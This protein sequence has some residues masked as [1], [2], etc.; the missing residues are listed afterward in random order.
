MKNSRVDCRPAAG[1]DLLRSISLIAALVVVVLAGSCSESPHPSLE[2][3]V[4]VFLTNDLDTAGSMLARV[5]EHDPGN[6]DARA[7]YAEC[8]RRRQLFDEAHREG[9]AALAIE[10]G[11]SLAHT[12]LGDLF[13]P[14]L[15]S[16]ARTDFDSA[17]A[18]LMAAVESD[19]AEAQAW[20]SVWI[21]SMRR[22]DADMERRAAGAMIESGFLTPAL[23]AYNKWQLEHLPPNAILLT[24]GDMDTYPSV[25]LQQKEGF[26]Q[27]V[28]VINL[29]LLNLPWYARS[30]SK[31]YDIELP[32]TDDELDNL[33]AQ[34]NSDGEIVTSAMQ[35]VAGW[36]D[37]QRRGRL[38]RP[39][40][41]A[42]TVGKL[43]LIEGASDR[44]VLCGAYY[45]LSPSKPAKDFDLER[46][47]KSI[48]TVP[49]AELYG[50]FASEL[51]RSPVRRSGSDEIARNVTAV[52][53][54][55]VPLLV[56]EGRLDDA[57]QALD[58]AEQFDSKIK[59]GG[60]YEDA[61]TSLRRTIDAGT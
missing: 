28:A 18:H 3:S 13:S 39:L 21:H 26:R 1:W 14:R 4:Q 43:G 40:C 5:V 41:A 20:T 8:L 35:I 19:P 11:H 55:Y 44:R 9:N 37:M 16:W 17:W 60:A 27:D 6:A 34:M 46:M 25:A 22:G 47:E 33:R 54:R 31:R 52:M 38:E 51:D 61:F 23:L 10:P 49:A 29:S 15:S 32:V 12:V 58:A 59:A 42:L 56:Q 36:L 2:E 45:E 53:L 30:R 48:S 50:P 57:R 7:W 24:N